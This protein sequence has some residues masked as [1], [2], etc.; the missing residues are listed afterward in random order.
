VGRA[1][2][3]T[4]GSAEALN[5]GN[6][7]DEFAPPGAHAGA[8]GPLRRHPPTVVAAA[9]SLVLAAG[10][11]AGC[12]PAHG[13]VEVRTGNANAGNG[14]VFTAAAGKANDVTVT[15]SGGDLLISDAGDDIT[16][17]SGCTAVDANTARC[18]GAV[19]VLMDLGDGNDFGSNDTNVSSFRAFSG[20]A[21]GISGGPGDDVLNGGTAGDLLHGDEGT[22]TL[23]GNEGPDYLAEGRTAASTD[24]LDADTFSG[25]PGGDRVLYRLSTQGVSVDLDGVADDGLPTEGDNVF[26]DVEGIEGSAAPDLLI[27]NDESNSLAG[28]GGNDSLVGRRG[29]D[30]FFGGTGNDVLFEGSEAADTDALDV[31]NFNGDDGVDTVS[32]LGA[33]AGVAVSLDG[34]RNDG[35][36]GEADDVRADVENVTGGGGGDT[37]LGSAGDNGLRGGGGDD[38]LTGNEGTDT[39]SGE[40]ADDSLREGVNQVATDAF[41]ADTF[42]GGDGVDTVSY[43]AAQAGVLVDLDDVADDGRSSERDNVRSNVEWII[44]GGNTDRLVGD[45]D[46]NVIFGGPGGDQIFGNEGP[47]LLRGDA[48]VDRL[49]GGTETDDCDVGPDGG[50]EVNCEI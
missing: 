34:V 15:V 45:R 39:L 44:G 38:S 5:I 43:A 47:D 3:A 24:E 22:D 4:V 28:L 10:L 27:G 30:T 36:P 20:G 8:M 32:Y 29:I 2:T 14:M 11:L 12:G 23:K 25:G 41:D 1:I 48:G 6:F 26:S 7:T 40:G 9:A 46:G 31:D 37:L 19:Y 49:D 13:T 17:G 50:S 35:R 33:T 16:P 42:Q 18:T 21:A